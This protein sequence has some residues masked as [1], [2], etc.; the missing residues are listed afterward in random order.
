MFYLRFKINAQ[1]QDQKNGLMFT[2]HHYGDGITVRS[3][4]NKMPTFS[5]SESL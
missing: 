1:L 4:L 5:S 3:I 2:K